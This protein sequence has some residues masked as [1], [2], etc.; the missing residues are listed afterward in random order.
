MSNPRIV[1][2]LSRDLAAERRALV[3]ELRSSPARISPRYFYDPLGCALYAAIC[4]LPEYYLT[5]TER[6]IFDA[7]RADIARALGRGRQF[8]DLGAGDCRKGADWLGWILPSRY[9]AVDIAEE[10]IGDALARMAPQHPSIEMLGVVTDFAFGL[11]LQ[12]DLTDAP[13]TF[14]FP[15]SSIGNFTPDEALHL[16]AQIR[17]HCSVPGSGLLIG[18]DTVKPAPRIEAAY[19]DAL[20]VTAAFNRNALNHVNRLLGSDFVAAEW[21]HWA[22]YDAAAGRVEMHLEAASPQQVHIAGEV[23]SF[24]AG[25]RIHTENSFKYAPDA[26]AALLERAGFRSLRRWQDPAGDFAVFHAE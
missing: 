17:R 15:G 13:V 10:A 19:A 25:E 1:R 23:R 24:A 14:F 12:R 21:A 16:V 2:R 20:G 26:F 6:S 22:F 11:E 5:R 4:E 9:I 3:V 18:V 8:V 7:H